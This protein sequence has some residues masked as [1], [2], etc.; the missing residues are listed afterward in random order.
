M[1]LDSEKLKNLVENEAQ[2]IGRFSFEAT[3]FFIGEFNNK[4]VMISVMTQ[5][6]AGRKHDY[7]GI[8]SIPENLICIKE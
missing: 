2:D 3:S 1:Q 4:P 5:R 6:E 8:E 7:D